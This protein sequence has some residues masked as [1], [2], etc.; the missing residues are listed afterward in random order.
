MHVFFLLHSFL[1]LDFLLIS[2]LRHCAGRTTPWGHAAHTD[3]T[4]PNAFVLETNE[5]NAKLTE[6]FVK[7]V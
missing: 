4:T 6:A 3:E 1:L 2:V 7:S 5:K